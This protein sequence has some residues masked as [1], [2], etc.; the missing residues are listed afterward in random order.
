[1]N[2]RLQLVLIGLFFALLFIYAGAR[3]YNTLQSV[4]NMSDPGWSAQRVDGRLLITRASSESLE[5]GI[6]TGDEV[7]AINGQQITGGG[8]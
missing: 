5:A 7:V 1:M 4:K 2:K 3:V 6:R 8:A